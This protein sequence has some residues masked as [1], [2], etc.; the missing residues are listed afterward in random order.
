[1]AAYCTFLDVLV[2]ASD[3]QIGKELRS[4][5]TPRQIQQVREI[6]EGLA[7]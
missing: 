7:S 6:L 4:R 3:A 5:F 2:G 1:M